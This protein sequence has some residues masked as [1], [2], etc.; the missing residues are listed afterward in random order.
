M[1]AEPDQGDQVFKPT[2]LAYTAKRD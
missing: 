1:S 2:I